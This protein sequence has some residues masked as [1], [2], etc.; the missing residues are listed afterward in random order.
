MAVGNLFG[1]NI[2]NIFILGI[3]DV[4]YRGGS[5]FSVIHPEHLISILFVIIMTAVAAI[6]LLFKAEQKRFFLGADSFIILLL[7][8]GLMTILYVLK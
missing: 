6:G 4:F 3:D 7:Y 1:S 8:A 5:I 2:F